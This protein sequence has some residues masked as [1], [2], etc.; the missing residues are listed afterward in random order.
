VTASLEKALAVL[1]RHEGGLSNDPDDSGGLTNF[2]V[3]FR[4]LRSLGHDL[5]DVNH[6]GDINEAD[7]Y[8]MTWEAASHI[9]TVEFWDRYLYDMLPED[10]AIKVFD[11]A[12]NTGP[13]QAHLFLQRAC[14]AGSEAVKEDGVLGPKTRASVALAQPHILVACMRSESAGFYRQLVQAKPQL[15]RF[16]AGWLSRSYD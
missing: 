12:V 9:F 2:G 8:G 16:L 4:F 13:M 5:A 6:D 3:S 7:I 11:L 1:R 15:W 14:R 10:V